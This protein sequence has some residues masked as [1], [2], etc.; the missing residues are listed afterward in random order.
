MIKCLLCQYQLQLLNIG[1]AQV[2][3]LPSAPVCTASTNAL[4]DI[5]TYSEALDM[6]CAPLH[7][8]SS[9]QDDIPTQP[10]LAIMPSAP[11]HPLSST[12]QRIP[13][14]PISSTDDE[15]EVPHT[16]P[17]PYSEGDRINSSAESAHL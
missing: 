15:L 6:P 5:P 16:P 3:S 10:A 13:T 7:S 4:D 9:T 1:N 14:R 8:L 17:P 11:L 12:L 2:S